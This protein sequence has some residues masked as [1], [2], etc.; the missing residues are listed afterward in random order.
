V[1]GVMGCWR[2]FN[3]VLKGGGVTVTSQNRA[4]IDRVVHEYIGAKAE[5]EHCSSDWAK[6]GKKI[7]IDEKEKKKLVQAV[8]AALA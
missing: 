1:K 5:Y 2:W 4:K 8:K 7:K 3:S 6:L